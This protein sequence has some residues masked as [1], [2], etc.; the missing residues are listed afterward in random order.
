MVLANRNFRHMLG[1]LEV[2]HP[3][4]DKLQFFDLSSPQCPGHV[5]SRPE[6]PHADGLQ[7]YDLCSPQCPGHMVCWSEAMLVL[8]RS[9]HL[10]TLL[11]LNEFSIKKR[12]LQDAAPCPT[13]R[14]VCASITQR[15]VRL[16][17]GITHHQ[18]RH[19][20]GISHSGESYFALV[21]HTARSLTLPWYITQRGVLYFALVSHSAESSF[22]VVSYSAKAD[23]ALI[24]HSRESCF[25]FL[26]STMGNL[27]YLDLSVHCHFKIRI[28]KYSR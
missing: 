10:R 3:H 11:A 23:F 16:C 5:V 13:I 6:V 1:G 22:A 2:P 21:Y 19:C 27:C 4:A 26:Y 14:W 7:A 25:L 24:S 12:Q 28:L 17:A 8:Y 15:R 18:I 20:P 9:E